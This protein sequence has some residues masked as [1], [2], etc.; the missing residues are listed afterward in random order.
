MPGKYILAVDDSLVNRKILSKIISGEYSVIE[1]EN[2]EMAIGILRRQYSE[3]AAIILDIVMPVMD[4]Y[5]VLE[6]VAGD[7]RFK[8]I[9]IIIATEKSDNES[10][11]KALRLGAWD[12]V[13]KPYNGEIIK[14]RIKN[15][16]ERSQLYTLQQLRYLAEFDE[17]T[18]IYNKNKFYK[19]TR[20]M[21]LANPGADFV[22]IRFDVDRFQLINSFFGTQEGDRLLKY[23]AKM[24]SGYVSDKQPSAYGRI[25]ADVFCLCFPS[26]YIA[27]IETSMS[28][29]RDLVASYNL[30][31]DIVPSCGIYYITDRGMPIEIM[32]DRATLAAKRCKGNYVN[33]YAVYDGSMSAQIVREQEITNEMS[34]ALATGQFQIYLQP[35]YHIASNRPVG[36]EALVRWFHPQKGLIPPGDF[37]PVFERNGFIPKLDYYVWEEVCRLLRKWADEGRELYPI[38]VNISRVDLYNPRLAEKVI[39]LTEKYDLPSELLNLELTESAYTD[40]PVAMSETMAKLQ[41]KGFT[42]MMDDFGSGYSSLNILKDIS[43]DVLKID[44]RFLSKTKIPGRGENIIASVVRMAKWLHI[45]VIAEGVETKD[46]V[47][48][49]RS[50]GCEYVQ[51]F[52]FA[53]PMPVE[54]YADLVEKNGGLSQPVGASF[55]FSGSQMCISDNRLEE[56]FADML[57]PVAI[58]EFEND[59]VEAVRVNTPFFELLGY[60]DGSITGGTPL[61][62]IDPKYHD[63]IIDTFRRVAETHE[64]EECEYL[65]RTSDGKSKWLRIRLKYISKIGARCILVG[66]LTDITIQRELDMDSMRLNGEMGKEDK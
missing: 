65:R 26:S 38:S 12:F 57:Q 25:E 24:L 56:L 21:L 58:Y 46:Q 47:E 52:Y 66:V 50:I 18:G 4:G 9:P 53:K 45:P 27:D 13:S 41:S 28:K 7:E 6:R 14:F 62:L 60:D 42:I 20:E 23:I 10:E 17:L 37:V 19:S 63:S 30:N 35:K 64:E 2:G 61:D 31:Y 54:A 40:N 16:I 59:K 15:A 11:I 34:S 3:I 51:G 22:L 32:Y 55:E 8:N 48:F 44:M 33:F 5:L 43:V 36:A 1:A 49:L 29:I 39:E